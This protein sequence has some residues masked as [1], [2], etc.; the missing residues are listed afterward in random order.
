MERIGRIAMSIARKIVSGFIGGMTLT[1]VGLVASFIQFSLLLRYLPIEIVGIWMVFT[2]MGSYVMFFDLGMS[3]TLGRE[4][5]FAAGDLE[6]DEAA[7]ADRIGTLIRSCTTIV[8]ILAVVVFLIGVSGGWSYLNTVVPRSLTGE[9]HPAWIIFAAGAALNLIGEG[10]FA[11]LYGLGQVFSEKIVRSLGAVFGLIFVSIAIF[12]HSFIGLS[13]AYLLQA[14]CTILIARYVLF[15]AGPR[16]IARGQFQFSTIRM[17]VGPS[18]KYAATLL[19]GILILQT[20]NLVIASVLGPNLIPNYQAIAKLVSVMM[21]LS[22]MLVMTSLPLASQAHARRDTPQLLSLLN[23]NLRYSLS[24]MAILGSFVA[25]F[26]DRVILVWLG[27]NHFVGF[28]VVW[29]LLVVM[30]LET[31]HQSMAAAIM[32]TGK[33]VFVTPALIAGVLNIIFSVLLAR[34]Y[35]VIGV[36]IGTMLAQVTTNNWYAPWYTLRHFKIR[37]SEH[38]RTILL[39]VSGLLIMLVIADIGIRLLTAN[40]PVILSVFAGALCTGIVG[41]S[42]FAI[43][44]LTPEER[45]RFIGALRILRPGKPIITSD[46]QL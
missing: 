30:L 18:L 32:A 19:G 34:R 29:V 23:R 12:C 44:V 3:P 15:R 5:S 8:A 24:V 13:I 22:M 16:V 37:F 9:I 25:C 43:I 20:D 38:L 39:P 1:A 17:V 28:G 2:T 26:A 7:R 36:V 11:G 27:P 21:Q 31:H 4:I 40:I 6:L 42:F 14:M 41:L 45:R 33:I 35:G 46:V 10:W